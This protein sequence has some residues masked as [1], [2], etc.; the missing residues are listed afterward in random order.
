MLARADAAAFRTA[1]VDEM[2]RH[3]PFCILCAGCIMVSVIVLQALDGVLPLNNVVRFLLVVFV[4]PMAVVAAIGVAIAACT[5]H[6]RHD[7]ERA[8]GLCVG[9]GYDL[10]GTPER[11]PECGLRRRVD[12]ARTAA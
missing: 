7:Y 2:K 1:G 8:A 10:R 6:R 3:E 9:C 4:M 12:R 5:W 11:C